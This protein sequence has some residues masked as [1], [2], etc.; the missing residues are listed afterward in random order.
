MT[1]NV[2]VS[3]A[4]RRPLHLKLDV[5]SPSR[6]PQ[7]RHIAMPTPAERPEDNVEPRRRT[8]NVTKEIH[9]CSKRGRVWHHSR[10]EERYK[11]RA[12][13]H[14]ERSQT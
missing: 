14:F 11:E 8:E 5:L 7:K 12:D 2:M 1:P 10:D 3:G 6:S 9:S 4:D 13:D